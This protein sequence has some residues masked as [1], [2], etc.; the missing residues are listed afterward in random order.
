M[1][2]KLCAIATLAAVTAAYPLFK[3]CDGRWAS[4]ALGTS[5]GKTIC[6]AGCLMS[7]VSMVLNDCHKT[8]NGGA[9]DPKSLNSWLKV[10]GGYA[11]GNLFVWGAV[12]KF[13]LTYVGQITDKNQM[14]SYFNSG[15]A[16]ILNVNNGG[17]WV[18]MTGNS[19]ANFLVNDPGFAK[20]SYTAGEVVRAGIFKRPAGC[21]SLL[22]AP[23][24]PIELSVAE[25]IE[26]QEMEAVFEAENAT[27]FLQFE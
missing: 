4:D 13:G 7:S 17:H 25:M 1:F 14:H 5:G 18:L 12:S 27:G 21:S 19:G 2:A 23:A 24:E 16:V 6:Q 20:S 8:I 11:S 3:Q 10:N 26:F 22:Q 15:H 9:A